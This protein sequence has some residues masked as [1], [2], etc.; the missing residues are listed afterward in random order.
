MAIT[1]LWH[2]YIAR[3]I[4]DPFGYSVMYFT[5][6]GKNWK[7]HIKRKNGYTSFSDEYLTLSK[8]NTHEKSTKILLKIVSPE[9][10]V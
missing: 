9:A 7:E 5:P 8:A 4:Y 6:F 1:S 2:I 3:Y 10:N